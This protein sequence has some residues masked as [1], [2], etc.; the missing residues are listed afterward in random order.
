L[1]LGKEAAAPSIT[2]QRKISC[3]KKQDG[4]IGEANACQENVQVAA[5]NAKAVRG[6]KTSQNQCANSDSLRRQREA[7]QNEP[8]CASKRYKL[9]KHWKNHMQAEQNV[10]ISKSERVRSF[11]G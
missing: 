9:L 5:E 3:R 1:R 11:N 4:S 7:E 10:R 2:R 8:R 6:L